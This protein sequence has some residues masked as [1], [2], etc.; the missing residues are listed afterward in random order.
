MFR[1]WLKKY[2]LFVEVGDSRINVEGSAEEAF[3][4]DDGTKSRI[5]SSCM[6]FAVKSPG[7][8]VRNMAKYSEA[9]TY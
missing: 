6:F 7:T 8:K 1:V 3:V 2:K 5:R 9:Q 4:V